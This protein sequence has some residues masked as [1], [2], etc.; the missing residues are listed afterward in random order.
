MSDPSEIGAKPAA[1]ATALPPRWSRPGPWWGRAG[2]RGAERRVLGG[3]AHR[4][5][6][7]VRLADG[8]RA[9]V[10]QAGDH[11]GVVGRAPALEDLRRARGG[12][13]LRAEVVLQ[14]DRHPGQRARV[15][16][17]RHPAVDGVGR[18]EGLVAGDEVERVELGLPRRRCGRGAPPPRLRALRLAAPDRRGDLER[19][20]AVTGPPRAP[21]APGTCPSSAAGAAASTASRMPASRATSGRSTFTS[22]YGCE[23]G[24]HVGQ[25]E[26]L[27]VGG[28]L[29]DRRQLG[30]EGVE[31]L[32]GQL[33]PSQL[34]HVGHVVSGELGHRP[35]IVGAGPDDPESR[36]SGAARPASSASPDRPHE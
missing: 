29:E 34:G 19:G 15:L 5:L 31:L 4:E 21:A 12:D 28:V 18:R 24:S 26:R 33:Q 30:R 10:A 22:G 16:P 6:V 25:V 2:S 20:V 11:R 8:D 27:H 32:V 7:E 14:R 1:T 3:R 17:R 9:G 35:A 13:A 23:V 36:F